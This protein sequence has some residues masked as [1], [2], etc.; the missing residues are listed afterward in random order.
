MNKTQLKNV[1]LTTVI[2]SYY[3]SGSEG[4]RKILIRNASEANFH[5]RAAVKEAIKQSFEDVEPEKRIELI[6]EYLAFE[7]DEIL[8]YLCEEKEFNKELFREIFKPRD[9]WGKVE[10]TIALKAVFKAILKH[11]AEEDHNEFLKMIFGIEDKR[12]R[13]IFTS[14]LLEMTAE[15][16]DC[17][18]F[19]D[20]IEEKDTTIMLI[21]K[22]QL[23]LK[24]EAYAKT[25]NILVEAADDFREYRMIKEAISLRQLDGFDL[26]QDMYVKKFFMDALFLYEELRE[27]KIE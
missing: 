11:Y 6:G 16:M 2:D 7:P 5:L 13:T 20:L 18:P 9:A 21:L 10:E 26:T 17:N 3:A 12:L 8:L 25:L 27:G 19:D 1:D 24:S 4:R 23:F 15:Y 14:T 22:S